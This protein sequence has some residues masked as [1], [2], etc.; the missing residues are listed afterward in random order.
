M[1]TV[2]KY[3]LPYEAAD[4][5]WKL[6]VK[7]SWENF[8]SE[9]D[10]ELKTHPFFEETRWSDPAQKKIQVPSVT[11]ELHVSKCLSRDNACIGN[12]HMYHHSFIVKTEGTLSLLQI[13]ANTQHILSASDW[14]ELQ[15]QK[16]T[17]CGE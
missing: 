8:G 1:K 13:T 15:T 17:V 16:N 2:Y 5:I 12:I 11:N 14:N 3:G 10:T 6:L 7:D 4:F 9:N